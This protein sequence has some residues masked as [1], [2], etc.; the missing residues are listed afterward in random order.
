MAAEAPAF[1][2]ALVVHAHGAEADVVDAGDVPTAVVEARR[3]R[4]HQRQHVMV[5][6]V[7]AGHERHQILGAVGQAQ[8]ERA[9]VELDRLEHVAGEDQHMRQPTRPHR[10]R[11]GAHGGGSLAGGN[12][13]PLAVRFLVGRHLRRD[14]DFH[15][16][17]FV[18]AEPEAVALEPRRRIDQLDAF[19]FD[20][21]LQPR[22]VLGV[23]A[24][25]QVMQRLGLAFDD[26]AP[27]VV[28]AEGLELK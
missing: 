19:A 10:R 22:N 4:L 8:S 25:R 5:A 3:R 21:G 20:A 27:T 26:R 23:A 17:A 6:A 24:K 9:L 7:N 16:H 11:H 18:V 14:L 12:C 1:L 15:Q 2:I 28:V 13:H